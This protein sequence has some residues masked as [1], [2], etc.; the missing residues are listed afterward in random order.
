MKVAKVK[1]MGSQK[2]YWLTERQADAITEMTQSG[3]YSGKLIPIGGD[4]IKL[5]AVKSIE[6]EE[7]DFNI[8]PNY[9]KDAV[10]KEMN[11]ALPEPKKDES[12]EK[13]TRTFYEDGTE[14]NLP[15][16]TLCKQGVPF[17]ER[18]YAIKSKKKVVNPTTGREETA[19]E[20]GEVV[21][22]R[23]IG[24]RRYDGYYAPTM[25]SVKRNGVEIL[26]Y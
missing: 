8:S 15:Y 19:Y 12:V 1:V 4:R 3:Q 6:I 16:A 7:E 14:V 11:G 26:N 23:L 21:E 17:I 18:D 9:F 5:S 22:E 25:K 10:K 2:I 20:L 24:F 13:R